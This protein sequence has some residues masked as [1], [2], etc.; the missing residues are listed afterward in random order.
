MLVLILVKVI[1]IPARLLCAVY[2]SRSRR[3]ELPLDD[4]LQ[5]QSNVIMPIRIVVCVFT[6]YI[7]HSPILIV[8]VRLRFRF[9]LLPWG[10]Q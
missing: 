10:L 2:L 4:I 1:N 7:I 5:N 3:L 8:M 9:I 6:G